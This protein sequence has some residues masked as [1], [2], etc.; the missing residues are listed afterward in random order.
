MVI[1]CAVGDSELVLVAVILLLS[2]YG[3]G[4]C[5][6]PVGR[7]GG[8]AGGITDCLFWHHV[9]HGLCMALRNTS[10]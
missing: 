9:V 3:F 6:R 8:T 10:I 5:L 7:G 2:L 4:A 1:A